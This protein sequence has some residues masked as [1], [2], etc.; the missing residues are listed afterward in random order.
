M[1]TES[2]PV[3]P[4]E[5]AADLAFVADVLVYLLDTQLLNQL[6]TPAYERLYRIATGS[7]PG[8][9]LDTASPQS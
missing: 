5:T 1:T 2:K 9:T 8:Q 4:A 7:L 6:P 3:H